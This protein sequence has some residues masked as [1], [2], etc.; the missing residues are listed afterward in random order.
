MDILIVQVRFEPQLV[1]VREEQE[2]KEKKNKY[3]SERG[4]IKV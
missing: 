2:T 4:F 1:S 3:K